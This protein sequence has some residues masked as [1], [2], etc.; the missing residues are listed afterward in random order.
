MNCP[1]CNYELPDKANFC[2][3]CGQALRASKQPFRPNFVPEA[4]RKR[5]TALFSDLTGYSGITERLDPEEVKEITSSIF[6]GIRQVIRKYEGFIERFAGDGVLVLFGVPRTHEDDAIRAVR[7][8]W[9]IHQYVDSLSPRYEAKAGCVLSMHSGINTGLAVTGDNDRE[10]GTYGVTGESINVA[11]R[12]SDLADIGNILVGADTYNVTKNHF[13][14]EP[15]QSR[16]GKGK[17]ES[18]RVYKVLSTRTPFSPA[19]KTRQISS[20]MLGRNR[21]MARLEFQVMK[22]ING[23]GSVVNVIGE[24]GIGKSRIIAELRKREVMQRVLLLEG[25]AISIGRNLNFHPIIDLLKQWARIVE[26]D[27]RSEAFHKLENAVRAVHPE[28]TDEILPFIAT[29]MGMKL[30]GKHAERV[31]GIEGE[32]LEVMIMKNIRD[33]LVKASDL[34]PLVIVIEDLH[35]C[36]TSSI[37]LLIS[38]FPLAETHKIVFVNVFRPGHKETGDRI[39]E[40]SKEE[41][42]IHSIEIVL[43][44][45]DDSI[46]EALTRNLARVKRHHHPIIEQIVR[47]AGGNPFFIEEVVRSFIDLGALSLKDGGFE[48]TE[49]IE[50]MVI[51]Q[52]IND[53][54]IARIDRLDVRTRELIKVASVIGRSFF[55]RILAEAAKGIED[56]DKRLEYLK[57]IQIIRERQCMEELEYLFNHSLVQEAAYESILIQRRRKLHTKT[58]DAIEAVFKERLHEFYGTLAYHYIIGENEEKAERYLIKAGEEALRSSASSEALHYFKKALKIY[59]AKYSNDVDLEKLANFEKNIALACF[60][61]AQWSE[62]VEY[63]DK[64][65][66][67]WGIAV[68]KAG[69]VGIVKL[70]WYLLIMIKAIYW[71]LPRSSKIPGSREIEGF[72]LYYKEGLS[73]PYV[74]HTRFFVGVLALFRRTLKYNLFKIPKLSTY[75]LAISTT[76]TVSGLSFRLSNRLLE[77]SNRYRNKEDI[78]SQMNYVCMSTMIYHCQGNW[79]KIIDMDEDLLNSALR[80]GDRQ[81]VATYLWFYGLIKAEQGEFGQLMKAVSILHDIGETYDYDQVIGNALGL[82]A[83]Y[84]I[85]KRNMQEA[86]SVSEQGISY[87]REK[88]NEIDEIMFLGLKAEIQQLI[89]DLEGAHETISQASGLYKMQA[90]V[91]PLYIAPYIISRFFIDVENLS[92]AFSSNNPQDVMHFKKSAY[93]S[94]KVAVRNS[95]KY[96]PYRTKTL[97]LMGRYYWLIGKQSK[98]FKW[99]NKAMQEGKRLGTRPDLSRTYFEVGKRLLE[100]KSKNKKFNGN[101]AKNYLDRAR[102]MFVDMNLKW[103]LDELDR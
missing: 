69:S 43:E 39:A 85:K 20:E 19:R 94:G 52:R 56:I 18:I 45:L 16:E 103:D 61:R 27:S 59:L 89:K 57:E 72:E 78:G 49:K 51:P 30:P 74:D 102:N 100:P 99:W 15:F 8:A 6:D 63:F 36:D 93:L 70:I 47:R 90:S 26:D 2:L 97:R 46:S 95:R 28:N 66:E 92:H 25:R 35:W 50:T 87:S 32:A 9:E 75:W 13:I 88:G 98:A 86:L 21:E 42:P 62:A 3:K 11:A 73:L 77:M 82:K 54:I 5:I 48:V 91:M 101:D 31:K 53:V 55:Y 64:V 71:K 96:A 58:A 67:R 10:K 14:F 23:E 65:L 7:A 83:D 1:E 22:A 17:Y 33:I 12:L 40:I 80:I 24:A 4:E 79:G 41:F 68:P 84:F 37:E 76:F 34:T 81:H 38:L 60:N 29:L 44:A